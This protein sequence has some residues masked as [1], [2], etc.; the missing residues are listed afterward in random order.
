M[1]LDPYITLS[2]TL[3]FE[4][5]LHSFTGSG[6]TPSS[7]PEMRL[8]EVKTGMSALHTSLQQALKDKAIKKAYNTV[9]I[10]MTSTSIPRVEVFKNQGKKKL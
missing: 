9:T 5:P 1:C 4:D 3:D 2:V 10:A 6:F 8:F 7:V